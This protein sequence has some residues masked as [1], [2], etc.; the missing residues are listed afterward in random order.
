MQH[1]WLNSALRTHA[2]NRQT[3]TSAQTVRRELCEGAAIS[4]TLLR[5]LH[6]TAT[7]RSVRWPPHRRRLRQCTPCTRCC[8]RSSFAGA[9]F[10][11]TRLSVSTFVW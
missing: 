1:R 2:L 4:R 11:R 3:D 9:S 5:S 7:P 10:G 8:G 6:P